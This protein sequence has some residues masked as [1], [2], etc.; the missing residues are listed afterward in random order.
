M[1]RS[2]MDRSTSQANVETPL[3]I[4]L[5]PGGGAALLTEHGI[6]VLD[7]NHHGSE[8]STNRDLHEH[9]N[10]VMTTRTEARN[11]L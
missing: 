1:D 3:A 7:V 6:E 8:S 2:F 10:V 9:A 5:M 11:A 4:S